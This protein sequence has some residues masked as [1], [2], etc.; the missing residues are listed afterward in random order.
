MFPE[1]MAQRDLASMHD[2]M[3]ICLLWVAIREGIKA[4]VGAGSLFVKLETMFQDGP[5]V[6]VKVCFW[7]S[8]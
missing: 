7:V 8:H 3:D 4:H 2:L 1:K 5:L 6:F